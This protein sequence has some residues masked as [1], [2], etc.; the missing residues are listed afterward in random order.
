M[1]ADNPDKGRRGKTVASKTLRDVEYAAARVLARANSLREA[2]PEILQGICEA[3]A[4]DFGALWTRDASGESLACVDLWRRP[5][6]G[7]LAFER[8]CRETKFDPGVG[9][10]GR[11]WKSGQPAWIEDVVHDGNFPRAP[12]AHEVGLHGALGFPII[13]RN[14][15]YG[16]I[17][18][19]SAQVHE[20]DNDLLD[21]LETIGAQ[22]GELIESERLG[23]DLVFQKALLE[24]Q[25]EAALDGILLVSTEQRVLYWNN[26]LRDM[27][28]VPEEVLRRGDAFEVNTYMAKRAADPNVFQEIASA[29][30]DHPALSRRDRIELTDGRML[31]RWTAPVRTP[32]GGRLGRTIYYRDVTRESRYEQQLRR[33][34]QWS[35]FLAEALAV[36][37][38]SL[39]V[40][41]ILERLAH[42]IVPTLADWCA[43]HLVD[44]DGVAQPIAVAHA[45]PEK[46]QLAREM[47]ERYPPDP[48]VET[49][50]NGVIRSRSPLLLSEIPDELIVE[51]ARD[52]RHLA[53]LRSL[54][55]R[56][57]VVAPIVCRDRVLGT[58]TLIAAE[59]GRR[60]DEHE[61]AG[62]VE[63]ASRAAFPIDNARLY[64]EANDVAQTLQ[65]SFLPPE[66][67][68]IPGVDVA[69]RYFPAT[70]GA[71][72]SGDF[73]DAFRIDAK[74][75]G[76]V[77]GDV[78]GKG[79]DAAAVTALAR[80]TIRGAAFTAYRPS[81][82]LA[83]LNAAL[84]EQSQTDRFCTA[85]FAIVEP[86]FGRVRVTVS[87]G[88]HPPPYVVR[89]D[90]AVEAVDCG[91]TLLGF[92]E[93]VALRD[94]RL[95]LEF[96]DK[97]FLYTDGVLDIRQ[98]GGMFGPEGLEKLLYETSRRGTESAADFVAQTLASMPKE[99]AADD[100]AFMLLGVRSS[101]FNVQRRRRAATT[102]ES[103]TA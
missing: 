81:E 13:V 44:P 12:V 39:D 88:G 64:A 42:Q 98:K 90:G 9:L 40:E 50:I 26:K 72:I 80:H 24:S 10:P 65:K 31:D 78:S 69:A 1:R 101:V 41:V 68:D 48:H 60:F 37:S 100:I 96:G 86:K 53:L 59:S 30:R 79:L 22:I 52:E 4:W 20:P 103:P 97:L 36:L 87:A 71:L 62:A 16:V 55:L 7:L 57:A 58:I 67:P 77:L 51:S 91:G 102:G 54:D 2:A 5:D 27:W 94:E 85:V 99:R 76:L 6:A 56:S 45:D 89:N 75:W 25:G 61:V 43:I 29:I 66:L 46:V 15:V 21:M 17:E 63:L 49:G 8:I 19:F 38:E 93:G 73:Y 95:E 84:L 32:E 35:S 82:V 34:E 3:L 28:G 92:I 83:V 18:F 70:E 74:R 14:D 33:N 23:R 47:Q 11:V